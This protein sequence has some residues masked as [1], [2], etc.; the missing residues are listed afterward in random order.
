[1]T[2]HRT[3]LFFVPAACLLAQNP[4]PKATAPAQPQITAAPPSFSA[5]ATPA[6]PPDRV[7]IAVGDF[8]LTAAQYD[9]LVSGLPAQ[10]QA[11]ARGPAKKQFAEN[12]VQVFVLAEEGKRRKLDE[13]P[14]YKTQA[15]FQADNLLAARSFG[16]LEQSVK[17]DDAELQ[18][19]YEDHKK[20][21]E[22]VHARHILIRAS[23]SPQAA[24]PGKK[25]L[26]D[27]EALAKAQEIRKKLADGADFAALAAAESDDTGTRKKGGDLNFFRRGQMVPQFEEAAFALNVGEISQPV[28]TQYG[29]HI[30]QVEGKKGFE[31]AKADIGQKVRNEL[32]RKTLEELQKS[33]N[34]TLDPEFFAAP[35]PSIPAPKAPAAPPAP[36]APAKQ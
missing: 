6:V 14:E 7:V 22:Q 24:E 26:S 8:K 18:K 12:L 17:V 9:Q 20:E 23:G 35:A 10:T 11:A 30:I 36:A 16:L 31:E 29:Y 5:P 1:M 4:A 13:T 25:E 3:L 33:A 28:K 32:A 21:Y 15:E 2:L 27:Q 19:Y 34:V